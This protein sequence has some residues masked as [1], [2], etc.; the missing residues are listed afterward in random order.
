MTSFDW[1]SEKLVQIILQDPSYLD[2]DSL[3]LV[4][5]GYYRLLQI[6]QMRVVA[7]TFKILQAGKN[8]PFDDTPFCAYWL[9][10]KAKHQRD[11]LTVLVIQFFSEFKKLCVAIGD[12]K[13]ESF[14]ASRIE[15]FHK[16]LIPV[17]EKVSGKFRRWPKPKAHVVQGELKASHLIDLM[18]SDGLER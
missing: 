17:P 11:W 14:C 7:D 5:H 3:R 18:F 4:M 16:E 10:N 9:Y 2:R 13:L 15:T 8:L 6:A 12:Q 1:R